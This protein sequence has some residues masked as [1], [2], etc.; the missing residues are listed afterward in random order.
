MPKKIILVRHG[1]TDF[2]KEAIIQGQLDTFLDE[3]GLKQAEKIAHLLAGEDVDVII[4]S[5]LKR[6]YQTAITIGQRIKKPVIKTKLLRERHFGKLQGFK[7]EE[8]KK[9]I[10]QFDSDED[11]SS[12]WWDKEFAIETNEQVKKRL[13]QL[14]LRLKRH[15]NKT[16]LIVTHGATIRMFLKLFRVDNKTVNNLEI[17]NTGC[18]VLEKK[19]GS[20]YFFS[21]LFTPLR[22]IPK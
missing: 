4:S 20:N 19:N 6:A 16:I 21:S 10:H 22:I 13:D 5:D 2:N 14:I 9:I 17:K 8:I 11:L 1:Q 18:F 7:K 12:Y 15:K 3:K